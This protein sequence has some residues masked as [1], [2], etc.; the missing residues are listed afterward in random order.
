[1]MRRSIFHVY[2]CEDLARLQ[3]QLRRKVLFFA[4]GDARN[5]RSNPVY[6][7]LHDSLGLRWQRRIGD[8]WRVT[9]FAR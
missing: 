7:R 5:S 6:S 1:M 2:N 3:P 9:L 8:N 4:G